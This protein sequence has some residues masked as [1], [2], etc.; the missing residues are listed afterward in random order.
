MHNIDYLIG[1]FLIKKKKNGGNQTPFTIKPTYYQMFLII[2]L[3]GGKQIN[4]FLKMSLSITFHLL[5]KNA[6]NSTLKLY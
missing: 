1:F 2:T 4:L 5:K 3:F 6:I